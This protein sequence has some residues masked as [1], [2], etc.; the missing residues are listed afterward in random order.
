MELRLATATFFRAFKGAVVHES[1]TEADMDL[2]NYTLISPRGK[3]CL[4]RV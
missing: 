3:K 4:I 1:L 2:E